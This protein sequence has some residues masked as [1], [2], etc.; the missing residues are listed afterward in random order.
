VVP[1]WAL[2]GPARGPGA[3]SAR[4]SAPGRRPYGAGGGLLRRAPVSPGASSPPECEKVYSAGQKS[5]LNLKYG[6]INGGDSGMYS[7]SAQARLRLA[8]LMLSTKSESFKGDAHFP[9]SGS[10][11]AAMLQ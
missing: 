1:T 4:S 2:L 6:D 11:R 9:A 8:S 3:A 5:S 10:V 7:E